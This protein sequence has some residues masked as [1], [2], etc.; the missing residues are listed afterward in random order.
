[1][2]V[3]DNLKQL[4]EYMAS[5]RIDFYVVPTSDFHSSEYVGEYFRAREYLSGFTGSNGTL[6]V[7]AEHAALWTDGRYFL[8]AEEQLKGSGIELMKMRRPGVPTL[9]EFITDN[10]QKDQT[11]AFDG[12][13]FS[14]TEG[15]DLE[16]ADAEA[17]ARIRFDVDLVSGI[18]KDRPS[19]SCNPVFI[20][21]EKYTGKSA[22]SKL[23]DIRNFMSEKECDLHIVTSLDDIAW[24]LNLR[25]SDVE[26]NPVFLSYLIISDKAGILFVQEDAVGDD[27][28]EYLES[29]NIQIRPYDSIYVYITDN[30]FKGKSILID[31][32]RLNYKLYR[33]LV[34]NDTLVEEQNPS[35]LMKACKN[36]IEAENL[37]KANIIDGVAM[38]RFLHWLDTNIGKQRIT[39]ISAADKLE[40]FRSEGEGF[41]G[42]S[43]HTISGYNEHGAIIHYGPTPETDSELQP[44]GFL[45]VDSGAQYCF[46]TT[47][48]TRTIALGELTEEMKH[49]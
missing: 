38:V 5:E 15:E 26:C 13:V 33:I 9:C 43:F 40:E 39:E 36:P 18:W 25:G 17:G 10:L 29:L 1:M 48:I 22:A 28:R 46:G 41:R 30:S 11:L 45:L 21:D 3:T 12:R 49:H 19:L 2:S 24:I 4:R 16:K 35:V 31:K 20:L 34:D 8:Q 42:I 14:V 23:E 44:N 37:R 7:T 27:V 47:D 32:N 6:L